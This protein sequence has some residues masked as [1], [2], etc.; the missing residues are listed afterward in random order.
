MDASAARQGR[1]R[2]PVDPVLRRRERARGPVPDRDGR[3]SGEERPEEDPEVSLCR[4]EGAEPFVP[5]DDLLGHRPGD[6]PDDR[7]PEVE[8]DRRTRL[9]RV[10]VPELALP[11]RLARD[12]RP[13]GEPAAAV[14]ARRPLLA[15]RLPAE[16]GLAVPL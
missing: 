12:D 14:G 2:P 6:R 15:L 16:D 11:C 7:L 9:V 1:E 10:A 4:R 13:E 8:V 3:R 5:E